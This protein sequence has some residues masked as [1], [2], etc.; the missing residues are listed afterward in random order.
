MFFNISFGL[1]GDIILLLVFFDVPLLLCILSTTIFE[2]SSDSYVEY[3]FL[4]L[5]ASPSAIRLIVALIF[6][7]VEL[8]E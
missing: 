8:Q 1:L 3:E 2:A 6:L 4:P 7:I 5:P